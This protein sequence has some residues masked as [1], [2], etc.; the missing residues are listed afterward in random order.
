MRMLRITQIDSHNSHVVLKLEGRLVGPWVEEVSRACDKYL[1][2]K[3]PLELDLADVFYVDRNGVI[4]LRTLKMRY[5]QF[6]GC[7]AFVA[8]ELKRG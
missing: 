8:E 7:S 5:V 4:L 6:R 1:E 3:R 2:S